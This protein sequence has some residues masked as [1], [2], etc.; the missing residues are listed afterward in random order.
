MMHDVGGERVGLISKAE[1]GRRASSVFA[2]GNPERGSILN[3]LRRDLDCFLFTFILAEDCRRNLTEPYLK[4]MHF[5][6]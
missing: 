1:G 2:G 3:H 4:S 6:M 5:G